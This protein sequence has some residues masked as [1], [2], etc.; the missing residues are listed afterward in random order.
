MS[1]PA[2]LSG[3]HPSAYRSLDSRHNNYASSAYSPPGLHYSVSSHPAYA[4]HSRTDGNASSTDYRSQQAHN[5]AFS[6]PSNH[7]PRPSTGSTGVANVQV[8]SISPHLL[9]SPD[10]LTQ[11]LSKD[12]NPSSPSNPTNLSLPGT[13][14]RKRPMRYDENERLYH[15]LPLGHLRVSHSLS[16][17]LP[18]PRLQVSHSTVFKSPAR[19]LRL[20]HSIVLKTFTSPSLNLPLRRPQILPLGH[21]RASHSSSLSLPLRR[22]QDLHST[23]KYPT[24]SYLLRHPPSKAICDD[25]YSNK[26]WCV[27]GQGMFALQEINQMEREMCSY[28]E[29]QPNVEPSTL[30]E[31]KTMVQKD[32][33]GPGS[34]PTPL[35][36]TSLTIPSQLLPW[37]PLCIPN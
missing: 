7:S 4:D 34:Y 24:L 35:Y 36:P 14:V 27:V 29:W 32:F 26:S 37:A 17:R 28:L 15:P 11:A 31:L 25:T 21:L 33:K 30:K 6:D 22:L 1:E 13:T 10:I 20:S 12:Q 18:P 23:L 3:S 8:Q 9:V 16:L 5:D 2:L 19:C